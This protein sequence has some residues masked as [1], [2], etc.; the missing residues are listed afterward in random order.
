MAENREYLSSEN[1][2]YD[3]KLFSLLP[4][5]PPMLL[6]NDVVEVNESSASAIAFIDDQASFFQNGNGIPAWIGLEYM[7][8]TAALIA[9]YQLEHNLVKPHLGFLLGTRCY[10]TEV[11]FFL[12][13]K[14]VLINCN[15]IAV[16]GDSLATFD[17]TI[18]HIDSDK[19]L[20]NANLSVYRQFDSKA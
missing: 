5:R 20:A 15:E 14:N 17:C 16:V 11:E 7:G 19:V 2:R 6:I 9:G 8:Q 1:S 18:R 13:N 10:Q 12:P 3:A 4:H